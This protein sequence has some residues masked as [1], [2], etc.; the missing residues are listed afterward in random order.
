MTYLDD[1]YT[2]LLNDE[3]LDIEDNED[4]QYE[5]DTFE[6]NPDKINIATKEPT[7]EQ[8]LRRIGQ[9]ALNLSPDF[10]RQAGIWTPDAKSR[11]IESILI[12]IPL[13]A[14]YIDATNDDQWV[15]V[16]G[17]QRLS[18][19]KEFVTDNKL[20][21]TGLEYLKHLNGKTYKELEPKYQRRILETQPTIYLIEKGTPPEV[22]YNIFK[23][24]NTGGIPLSNQELRHALNPGKANKF[25]KEL[26]NL[27]EFTDL[28]DLSDSKKKRMDDREFIL[29]HLAFILT[30][31]K[32]YKENTRDL[33]LNEALSK[34]N[35]LSDQELT[36]IRENFK[37]A[38]IAANDIFGDK[39]FRKIKN[40][41][42]FPVNKSLFETWSFYLSQLSDEHIQKL[43]KNKQNLIDKLIEYTDNDQEFLSSISQAAKKVE[44]RFE[45]IGKII[46]EVLL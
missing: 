23:R 10:Q 41:R 1:K 25:V 35:K 4:E 37:R 38:M 45:T 22:K 12:R 2:E 5:K 18:A 32:D 30:S 33:F 15:V 9:E 29:G 34:I 13:P 16:D 11:L 8:L 39:A 19:L 14:F 36:K 27:P 3:S 20:I 28:I 17:L 42:R 24:I 44:Y 21:L 46:Q 7:I 26:A 6:Y 40:E 31:Y 43:I